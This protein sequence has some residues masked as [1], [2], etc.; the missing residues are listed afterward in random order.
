MEYFHNMALQ[1]MVFLQKVERL[2][3]ALYRQ[4]EKGRCGVTTGHSM[5]EE[6]CSRCFWQMLLNTTDGKYFIRTFPAPGLYR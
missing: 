3:L 5:Q 1:F 2:F 4:G 6:Q